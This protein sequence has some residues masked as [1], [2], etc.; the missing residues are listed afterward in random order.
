MRICIGQQ[1]HGG[2]V[3]GRGSVALLALRSKRGCHVARESI[4][5]RNRGAPGASGRSHSLSASA[6]PASAPPGFASPRGSPGSTRADGGTAFPVVTRV[7][8]VPLGAP[9]LV[10]PEHADTQEINAIEIAAT[11]FMDGPVWVQNWLII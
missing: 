1:R 10:S 6:R 8:P 3:Q 7:V 11:C 9:L 5:A 4:G 2:T